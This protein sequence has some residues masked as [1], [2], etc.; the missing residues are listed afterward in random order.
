M[1]IRI[2]VKCLPDICLYY[3]RAGYEAGRELVRALYNK[4]MFHKWQRWAHAYRKGERR[5]ELAYLRTVMIAYEE[6]ER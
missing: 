5:R 4:L 6:G 2:Y 3:L 1:Y